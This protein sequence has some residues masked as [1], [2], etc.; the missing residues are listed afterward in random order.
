MIRHSVGYLLN[1]KM[2]FKDEDENVEAAWDRVHC[3]TYYWFWSVK[4]LYFGISSSCSLH[5][6]LFEDKVFQF[7]L[8]GA[9]SFCL[10]PLK[11]DA[12]Q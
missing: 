4:S 9:L 2:V 5:S 12:G 3:F 8:T 6:R 7:S 1:E 10:F 11:R